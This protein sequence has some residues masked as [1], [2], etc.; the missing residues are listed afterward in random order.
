MDCGITGKIGMWIAVFLDPS[1][2]Q[3]AVVVDGSLS[4]LL[5]VKSSQGNPVRRR[6]RC[7]AV[8]SDNYLFLGTKSEYAL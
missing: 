2:K 1:A 8:R 3:Q 6:L 5:P 4:S 7:P